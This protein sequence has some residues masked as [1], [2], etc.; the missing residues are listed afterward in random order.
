MTP[1]L[2]SGSKLSA[3]E[4]LTFDL[5][6]WQSLSARRSDGRPVSH[7]PRLLWSFYLSQCRQIYC[8][9]LNLFKDLVFFLMKIRRKRAWGMGHWAW[10]IKD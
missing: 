10:D 6:R 7:S 3:A 2:R 9:L 8:Y 4:A 5:E 1:R